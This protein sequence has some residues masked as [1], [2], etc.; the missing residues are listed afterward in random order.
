MV[1]RVGIDIITTMY[2]YMKKIFIIQ[3]HTGTIPSRIV[4]IFTQYSYSHVGI[5]FDKSCKTIYSF[6]RKKPNNFLIGGFVKQKSTDLI[7]KKCKKIKCR[8][9]ELKIT[10]KQYNKLKEL[11]NNFYDNGND[12]KYDFLGLMLRSLLHL[13]ITFKNKY[14]CSHFVA[15]VLDR[16]GIYHFTRRTCM[17]KP[18]DFDMLDFA[19]EVY[20]LLYKKTL[21]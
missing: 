17:I 14:V 4:K 18:R 12:F 19:S 20:Q 21:F 9:L 7:F 5:S 11:L 13:P 8:V 6:G 1:R 3:M 10:D 15:E 16:V 2:Y